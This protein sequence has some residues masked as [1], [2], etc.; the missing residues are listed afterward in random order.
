[1]N[2]GSF[3]R[4]GA[5]GSGLSM[6]TR[7]V[8]TEKSSCCASN[9]SPLRD[10][11]RTVRRSLASSFPSTSERALSECFK[12]E[13]SVSSTTNEWRSLGV[14][15][16]ELSLALT[17]PTGQSFRWKLTG[18]CEYTGVVDKY[19]F[20]LRQ[21]PTDVEYV[22]HNTC[23]CSM[24]S[25][26]TICHATHG[27][28][29]AKYPFHT[30][31]TCQTEFSGGEAYASP[32]NAGKTSTFK[33][34]K[35]A[36]T[37]Y[38]HP[39]HAMHD[40]PG[41]TTHPG[42][43]AYLC[44]IH[45]P[46][47]CCVCLDCAEVSLKGY[48][49]LDT[50]LKEVWAPFIAAD[51]RF[52][53]V[54]PYMRG[55]RLL[56]QSPLEC[57]FQFICSS[58]NHIQRISQM[59]DHLA[60]LG[61]YLGNV[62]GLAFHAFPTLDTLAEV[63]EADLRKAGFGYRAKYI[64]GAVKELQLKKGGGEEW[65]YSLRGRTLDDTLAELCSLPG[66]GPKVAACIALFSLDQH[67]AIPVDTHVWQIATNYIMPE[68]AGERLTSK[69]HVA[70]SEAFVERFG[71]YAGWAQNVLFI[72]ELSSHQSYLPEHLRRCRDNF[73]KKNGRKKQ[74]LES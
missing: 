4:V 63:T 14:D 18:D 37:R 46:R 65:L 11:S 50:S 73:M 24:G 9:A 21:T 47:S 42:G 72:A 74:K 32:L 34:Y 56:R 43:A 23:T 27:P 55:A 69:L 1:M 38:A 25:P 2:V 19:I 57:L 5:R 39:C 44:Q 31:K 64:V 68:L 60:G 49:N 10:T 58:N 16:S 12:A 15:Q 30:T 51:A 35:S 62:A 48:L 53:A 7:S 3:V 67:H 28:Y 71:T 45:G 33:C 41:V 54:A 36:E 22:L 52:S 40:P 29:L 20:T 70:V 61:P 13:R 17:L 26:I 59:V 66:I 6:A 8:A